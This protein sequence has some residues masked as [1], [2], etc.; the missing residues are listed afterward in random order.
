M[1]AVKGSTSSQNIR[2]KAPEVSVLEFENYQEA[3]TALK[4]NQGQVLTTDNAI[5]FGMADED[6]N[7]EVV[8][9]TFTDEPYGIA[10]KKGDQELTD[11]INKALKTLKDNGEYDKILKKWIKE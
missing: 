7:Y 10:V 6:S 8:G 4:S 9:G 11:A 5:L 1:L 3:F 2:E